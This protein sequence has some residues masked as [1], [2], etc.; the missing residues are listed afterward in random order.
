MKKSK[1]VLII[2]IVA[3]T[4]FI[5]SCI[6]SQPGKM[7]TVKSEKEL[8]QLY[9]GN[10]R[11]DI[12]FMKH[13]ITMPFSFLIDFNGSYAYD[14]NINTQAIGASE[15]LFDGTTGEASTNSKDYSE[16]NIQVE[17]VDEA[18]ILKT[19]GDYIYS[20]SNNNIP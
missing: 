8:Y 12:S 20:I 2:I 5:A 1:I 11:D 17:G 18:D 14:K 7:A 16:T 4:V 19:D 9:R 10:E 15:D 13:L 6:S 3:I